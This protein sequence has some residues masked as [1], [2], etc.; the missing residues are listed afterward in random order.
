MAEDGL[1]EG[2]S[3][4]IFLNFAE[5]LTALSLRLGT[6]CVIHGGQTGLIGKERRQE[7]IAAFNADEQHLIICNIQAGGVG[8]GLQ[9]KRGGRPR[10]TLISPTYS[11][12]ELVQVLGRAPRG[13]GCPSV[14]KII[15]CA[16]TEEE[17][18]AQVVRSKIDRISLINDGSLDA[19]LQF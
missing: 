16:D 2:N 19:A 3:V 5:T 15:F 13:G 1:A 6:N 11:G 17:H 9:G 7:N 8:I 4:A 12:V 10:L 14:Q 18:A